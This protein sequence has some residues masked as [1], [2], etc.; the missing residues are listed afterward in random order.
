MKTTK[1]CIENNTV[2]RA[3]WHKGCPAPNDA[4]SNI[5]AEYVI[6]MFVVGKTMQ[7]HLCV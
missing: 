5:D 6:H 7:S 4:M 2:T 1:P 3:V